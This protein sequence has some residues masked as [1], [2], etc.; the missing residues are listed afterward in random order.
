MLTILEILPWAAV[1]LIALA[2]LVDWSP[3]RLPSPERRREF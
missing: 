3:D 2:V 1:A